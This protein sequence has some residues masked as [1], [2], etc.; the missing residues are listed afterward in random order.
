MTLLDGIP[1]VAQDVRDGWA[2]PHAPNGGASV[3]WWTPPHVFDALGLT[4]D[5]D[6]CA[7]QG[8]VPW[9][10][11]AEHIALPRDGLTEPWSGRVWCNPPYGAGVGRWLGRLRDH[12]HGVALVFSRT[13]VRWWHAVVPDAS[14]V[15][16]VEGRITFLPG[17][18]STPPGNSGGPSALIAFGADCAEAVAR[19]GLGITYGRPL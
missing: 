10:P 13:D 6:V 2:H 15:C 8:G 17:D 5:L 11:A 3:D 16:F 12:G 19:S 1:D 18:G 14:A 9:I 7:P 4:F